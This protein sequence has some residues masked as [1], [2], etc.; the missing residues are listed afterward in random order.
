MVSKLV[1]AAAG[2]GKTTYLVE[3]AQKITDNKVLIT[4]F[5]ETNEQEIIRKFIDLNGYVPCNIKIQTWFSFLIQQGVKP[6]QSYLYTEDVMGLLLVNQK[7]A[8]CLNT[9]SS[10]PFYFPEK[11][12]ARHYFT[13]N[14]Q[15]YSDKLSKFVHRANEA[16]NGL[17]IDRISR[18]Y[19]YIFIDEVQ[20]LAG[21][22]LEIISLL[23]QQ[24]IE[25][26]MVGDPR[27]VTY[28]THEEQK[29][30]KYSEGKIEQFIQ[31]RCPFISID[32][33]TLNT[34]HRNEQN[35]CDFANS[36]YPEYEPCLADTK[37]STGHDGVFFVCNTDI[38]AY[39]KEYRPMQLRDKR[40]VVVNNAYAAINFGDSKGLTFERA[41]LYPTKPMKD[42][43]F[44]H[45][46][47]LEA[48]SR[49]KLYVAV[50]RASHSLAIVLDKPR[51]DINGIKM[52]KVGNNPSSS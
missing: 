38:D 40:T 31:E 20:D 35:I 47:S 22:D 33:K 10:K 41:L 37:A 2:S 11:N 15:I 1:I 42:W 17:I 9:K 43:I 50:T 29:N 6:Y 13:S 5:T 52:W 46:K 18:I 49:A 44:D 12:V 51:S 14:G 32:K 4:T 8:R 34:T 27:Q 39:L 16:N 24:N 3:E 7:S 36:I 45:N 21:Y 19:K 48:R 23:S 28:H 25:L 26:L 30:K